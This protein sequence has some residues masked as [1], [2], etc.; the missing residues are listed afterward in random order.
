MKQ[1]G[2]QLAAIALTILIA[3]VS[4]IVTGTCWTTIFNFT[5]RNY[6]YFIAGLFLKSPSMRKLEKE[7]HHDDSIYWETPATEAP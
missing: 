5:I 4:G 1:G 2:Y 3:V 6:V 7:E